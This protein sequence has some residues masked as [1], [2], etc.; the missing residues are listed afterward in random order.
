MT[1]LSLCTQAEFVEFKS[2]TLAKQAEQD[3]R[4]QRQDEEITTL[5]SELAASKTR[6][7][8]LQVCMVV[9]THTMLMQ[10]T[11]PN[12]CAEDECRQGL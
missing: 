7:D 12:R 1:V 3:A 4:L 11:G 5:T 9:V 8:A 10:G 6:E 2:V